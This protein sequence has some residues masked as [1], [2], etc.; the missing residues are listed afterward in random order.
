MRLL[1]FPGEGS[2]FEERMVGKE[3]TISSRV[4]PELGPTR[5]QVQPPGSEG[6]L[7]PGETQS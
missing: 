1:S 4:L 7:T 3:G 5:C 2:I 6:L